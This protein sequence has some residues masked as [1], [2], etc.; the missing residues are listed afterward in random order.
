LAV[1]K[2]Y[3][4][5]DLYGMTHQAFVISMRGCASRCGHVDRLIR[6]S[7]IPCTRWDAT[8]GRA[9][10]DDQIA[11]VYHPTTHS[12]RY[13]FRLKPG[14]IGCFLSHRSIWRHIVDHSIDAALI[15]E[16]DVELLPGFT[17][18]LQMVC[19]SA[20]RGS[21]TQFQTRELRCEFDRIDTH[22]GQSLLRPRIVPLRTTAQWVTLG[23]AKKLLDTTPKIDRPIDSFLQLRWLHGVDVL[24]VSPP[25][26]REVS[27]ALGGSMINT[28]KP[29]GVSWPNLSR[30]WKRFFY[31]QNIK[32]L[33]HA[34]GHSRAA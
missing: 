10:S 20:P 9:L 15:L 18:A 7:P 30:E 28:R 13:P 5:K 23:A 16:D 8:D 6:N 19:E 22:G 17:T 33:S 25:P 26:V 29:R 34:S 24:T 2:S 27:H 11:A 1:G 31:R 3:V 21:Y 12:P 4:P 14:E 32:R